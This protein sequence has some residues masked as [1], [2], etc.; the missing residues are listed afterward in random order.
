MK[1]LVVELNQYHTETFPIYAPLLPSFLHTEEIELHFLCHAEKASELSSV[2]EDISPVISKAGYFIVRNLQLRSNYFRWKIQKIIDRLDIDVLVFNSIEPDRNQK[3][4]KALQSPHKL[5]IVHNPAKLIIEKE[6]NE[7]YFVLGESVYEHFKTSLPLDAYLLPFF[8]PF[9]TKA[10]SKADD[11]L[12]IGVQGLVDFRRRDYDFLIQLAK[13]LKM[14]EVTSVRFNIIGSNNKKG[15]AR[16]REL[17]AQN[18]LG[19]YFILHEY[20]DDKTFF[21]EIEACDL[22]MTLLGEKQ[23]HYFKD[24]TTA[25]FSHAAAFNKPMLLSLDN[26]KAWSLDETTQYI[27]KDLASA[28]ELLSSITDLP[29]RKAAF[30]DWRETKLEKNRALLSEKGPV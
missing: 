24:K 29:S 13:N 23:K 6:P 18:D 9:Q 22:L 16:L 12:M 17:I 27:Y 3:V 26:A 11:C 14:K 19:N 5:A 20:L 30:S 15:G 8:K 1:L 2:Y 10:K 28:A 21:S 25:T 4:F 7:S